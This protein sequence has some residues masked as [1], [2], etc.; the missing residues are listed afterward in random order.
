MIPR[1]R[2][3]A[4]IAAAPAPDRVPAAAMALVVAAAGLVG[5]V[6]AASP[7]AVIALVLGLAFV[8]TAWRSLAAGVA[9]FALVIFLEQVPAVGTPGLTFSKLGGAV[10]AAVWLLNQLDRSDD[11]PQL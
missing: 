3:H 5:V 10:L 9:A 2:P 7:K 6:S 8:Y 1:E 4:A 11:V